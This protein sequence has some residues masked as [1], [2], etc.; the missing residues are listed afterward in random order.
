MERKYCVIKDQTAMP[1][2][3]HV[4]LKSNGKKKFSGHYFELSK[5]N[6]HQ[7]LCVAA[8]WTLA[9]SPIRSKISVRTTCQLL[10]KVLSTHS[11][12]ELNPQTFF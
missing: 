5:G 10:T 2:D 3:G 1:S 9:K 12:F 7:K 8:R 6:T 11:S 4:H